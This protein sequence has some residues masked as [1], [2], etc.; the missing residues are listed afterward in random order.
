MLKC[1]IESKLLFSHFSFKKVF[2]SFAFAF[3]L[4]F[5]GTRLDIATLFLSVSADLAT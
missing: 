3:N 4:P 1:E 5:L 2:T